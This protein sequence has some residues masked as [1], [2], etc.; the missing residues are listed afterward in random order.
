MEEF[1][2]VTGAPTR[3]YLVG[4]ATAVLLGWREATIDIDLK[5][6]PENDEILRSLPRLKER[7]QLNLELASP[8]DFIPELPGWQERS[9]FIEQI[10]S[11]SFLHYDFYA[12]VLAKIERGHAADQRDVSEM[13]KGGLVEPRRLLEFLSVI[14]PQLYRYPAVDGPSFRR[15]VERVVGETAGNIGR[16]E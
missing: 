9:R 14:E 4:G 1:G 2:Q 16:S 12:Q 7:L 13:I 5:I 6:V 15:A 10:G 3:V 8:D 11:V